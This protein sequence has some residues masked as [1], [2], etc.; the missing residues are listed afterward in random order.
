MDVKWCVL[1]F[2]LGSVQDARRGQ[3]SG[4]QGNSN[5]EDKLAAHMAKVTVRG[6]LKCV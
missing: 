2:P 3:N 4:V 6:I 5:V 1:S